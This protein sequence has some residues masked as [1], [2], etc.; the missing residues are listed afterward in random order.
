VSKYDLQLYLQNT[1]ALE[2]F[3]F[4]KYISYLTKCE[5]VVDWIQVAVHWASGTAR[6]FLIN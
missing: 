2:A 4:L 6:N 3:H 1:C 5:V